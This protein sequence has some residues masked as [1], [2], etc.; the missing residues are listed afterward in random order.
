[1]RVGVDLIDVAAFRARF[2]G[3]DDLLADTFSAAELEYCR[4]QP[5]PWAHLAARFAAREATLK[6]LGTG[7]AGTMA[8]RDV[9]GALDPA[10]APRLGFHGGTA[11][12]VVR[13]GVRHSTVSLTHTETHAIAVVILFSS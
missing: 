9:E 5:R 7:L 3:R 2:D 11:D 12:A 1:M 13:A 4:A 6:A 10:G 8:W